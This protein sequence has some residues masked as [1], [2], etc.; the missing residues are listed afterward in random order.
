[1]T[2]IVASNELYELYELNEMKE[3]YEMHVMY[4]IYK[5]YETCKLHELH[6]LHELKIFGFYIKSAY[7]LFLFFQDLMSLEGKK[8]IRKSMSIKLLARPSALWLL[9]INC[10]LSCCSISRSS[11]SSSV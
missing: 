7:L 10:H 1:M 6:K 8:S 9:Y 5:V 4:K 2:Y 3:M 11:T